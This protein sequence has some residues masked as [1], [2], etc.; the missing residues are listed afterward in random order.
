MAEDWNGNHRSAT[1][2]D[3]FRI[4]GGA[5]LAGAVA[6]I[7]VRPATA[8]PAEMQQAIAKIVGEARINTGKVTLN[9]PPLVENGNSVTCSVDVDSP[10]TTADHVKAIHIF[11]EQNP[12]P[13]V[14][15][16][17]LG[18]RAGRARF[19]TRIRLSDS[20]NV[21]AIAEMSDGSFWSGS[22]EVIVTL[23]ACLEGG[24]I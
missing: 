15:G 4:A 1:R 10:M 19:T 12:Q 17:Q 14:I 20:Q 18:P 23:S 9:L 6:L 21:I 16:V 7:T 22:A 2:R 11:N 13:N 3:L 8:T 24:A 5:A